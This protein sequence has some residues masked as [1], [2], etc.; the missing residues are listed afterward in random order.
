MPESLSF[1]SLSVLIPTY[2]RET[3]LAKALEGYRAQSSP[4]LIHELLVIDD[5]STDGTEAM[6]REFSG[7]NFAIPVG[8]GKS[9]LKR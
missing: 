2:N 8:Y 9:L 3:V 7:S 6:V 5:G 1:N 4:H